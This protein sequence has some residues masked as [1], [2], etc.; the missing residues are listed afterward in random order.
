MQAAAAGQRRRKS[1]TRRRN[2]QNKS[3]ISLIAFWL[4]F[5]QCSQSYT[6]KV[7]SGRRFA[8]SQVGARDL[9]CFDMARIEPRVRTTATA[10]VGSYDG[11]HFGKTRHGNARTNAHLH[12]HMHMHKLSRILHELSTL[13]APWSRCWNVTIT[14]Q[15]SL[16]SDAWHAIECLPTTLSSM[17]PLASY[18]ARTRVGRDDE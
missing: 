14:R 4:D 8:A 10:S 9:K 6:A 12:M 15:K 1:K 3:V 7:A 17:Q 5:R 2:E 18:H 11:S 13:P 16:G